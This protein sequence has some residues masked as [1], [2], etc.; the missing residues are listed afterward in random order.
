MGRAARGLLP[1]LTS[2]DTLTAPMSAT[3]KYVCRAHVNSSDVSPVFFTASIVD[4]APPSS[5]AT[6][7]AAEPKA[8]VQGAGA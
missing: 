1:P 8:A 5:R 6:Y 4:S 7:G 2:A 3:R